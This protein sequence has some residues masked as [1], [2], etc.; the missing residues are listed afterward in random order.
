MISGLGLQYAGYGLNFMRFDLSVSLH[1]IS[2]ILLTASYLLFFIGNIVTG[3]G[4]F[5]KMRLNSI[6][7]NVMIQGKYYTFGIF[8][9]QKPPFPVSEENKFNPLQK[10]SYIVVMYLLMPV[11]FLTGWA[12][13]FPEIV[14]PKIFGWSGLHMNDLLHIFSGYLISL[15]MFVHIYFCTFGATAGSNFRT[16]F[17]GWYRKHN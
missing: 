2:A 10:L 16:M 11:M 9:G 13:L 4:K 3:N 14:L 8:K 12:L 7:K 6:F 15:F 17:T 1:N 5:Y